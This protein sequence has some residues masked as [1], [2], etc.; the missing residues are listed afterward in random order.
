MA[1]I[2]K[3]FVHRGKIV[4]T[5]VKARANAIDIPEGSEEFDILQKKYYA[6]ELK[7]YGIEFAGR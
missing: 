7:K 3:R 1:R 2:E 5:A 4:D 6:E